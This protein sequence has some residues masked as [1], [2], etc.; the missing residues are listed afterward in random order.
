MPKSELLIATINQI[1]S[2]MI[3]CDY[4]NT[5]SM[6]YGIRMQRNLRHFHHCLFYCSSLQVQPIVWRA[7]RRTYWPWQ[8]PGTI[9]CLSQ[10]WNWCSPTRP[11]VA[12][13]WATS[14]MSSSSAG[15]C[16]HCW[17][18]TV[19]ERSSLTLT[20][21]TTLRRLVWTCFKSK[22]CNIYD[23]LGTHVSTVWTEVKQHLPLLLLLLPFS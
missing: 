22:M 18:S 15:L 8:R 10:P 12:S 23:L 21:A 2:T 17:S 20:H 1:T 6:L 3:S 19:R 16:P 14:Q 13:T 5:I 9:S 7:R 11:S 4:E